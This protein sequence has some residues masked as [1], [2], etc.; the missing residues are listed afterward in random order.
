MANKAA[1]TSIYK[2]RKKESNSTYPIK[3]VKSLKEGE[4]TY[5]YFSPLKDS[6]DFYKNNLP[7]SLYK[8]KEKSHKYDLIFIKPVIKTTALKG[9][10]EVIIHKINYEQKFFKLI[11]SS[12]KI[13]SHYYSKDDFSPFKIEELF[14]NHPEKL[15]EAIK[16][17]KPDYFFDLAKMD[18]LSEDDNLLKN[19][20]HIHKDTI[21]FEEKVEVPISSLF[22]SI[23]PIFRR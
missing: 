23:N 20:Y 18:Q 15:A 7:L 2:G 13:I 10:K 8:Y 9:I 16:K 12:D 6:D 11:K 14:S 5:Y 19:A 21:S 22:D 3:T 17:L 1:I 4:S